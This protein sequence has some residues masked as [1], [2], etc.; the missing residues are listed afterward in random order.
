MTTAGKEENMRACRGLLILTAVSCC[1]ATGALS[2]EEP[3]PPEATV[4][5]S[6]VVEVPMDLGSGRPVVR[7]MIDGNG[8]YDFILDTGAS[9]TLVDAGLAAE[10]GLPEAGEG[11]IGDPK[12]PEA[13]TNP[14][15]KARSLKIGGLELSGVSLITFDIRKMMGPTYG[16]IVGLPHLA[17]LLVTLDYPRGRV[18]FTRGELAAADPQAVPYRSGVCPITLPMT[19]T[20]QALTAHLDSG[21]PGTFM[22]PKALA[23]GWKFKSEPVEVGAAGTVNNMST[24]WSAQVDGTVEVGG[25]VYSDPQVLL[26]DLLAEWANMGF[27]ALRDVVLTV[28]QKN[29]RL[30]MVRSGEALPARPARRLVG[31]MFEGMERITDGLPFRDGAL[32]VSRV[33]PGSLAE[34]AGIRVGDA[35]LTINGRPVTA[36]GPQDLMGLFGGQERLTFGLRRAGESLKAVVEGS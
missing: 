28:D 16:G 9:S 14:V 25:L 4:L 22:L 11:T 13:F 10:L 23:K 18:V 7:V 29:Q 35:I 31:L 32:V 12:N 19:V 2:N 6:D 34:K 15:V 21:N 27:D 20:G 30:R 36:Y 8:P 26:S 24:I 33:G 3:P 1:G 17:D 5:E